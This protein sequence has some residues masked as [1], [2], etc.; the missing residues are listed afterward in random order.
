M[1]IDFILE[2]IT[3]LKQ[4]Q[5]LSAKRVL[6]HVAFLRHLTDL[7]QCYFQAFTKFG[8]KKVNNTFRSRI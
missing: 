6:E 1:N 3:F 8:N 4:M 7:N 2:H 5:S